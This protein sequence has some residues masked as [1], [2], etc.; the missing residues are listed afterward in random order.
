MADSLQ[1]ELEGLG[2]Q[3]NEARVYLALLELGGAPASAVAAQAGIDRTVAYT[4]LS[5]LASK[6]LA[7]SV[8]VEGRM[9]FSAVAPQRLVQFVEEKEERARRIVPALEKIL[10]AG[11]EEETVEVMRGRE[12][13][14]ALYD[15]ILREGKD[16]YSLGFLG[17]GTAFLPGGFQI[18][19]RRRVKAGIRR[20]I[21]ARESMR[22]RVG[23]T[24]F[25]LAE[26]RFLPDEFLA[27]KA[28]AV[29]YGNRAVIA[30]S[31]KSDAVLVFIHSAALADMY[32]KQFRLLWKTA[33]K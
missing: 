10:P 12:G 14:R 4:V 19:E 2:L 24:G 5:R 30:L 22:K 7:S 13:L 33:E 32:R 15:S 28:T 17:F 23:E 29:F 20:F 6:G 3:A 16:V 8:R 9:V 21:L 26:A 25:K 27:E 11:G 31:F 1:G 18:F